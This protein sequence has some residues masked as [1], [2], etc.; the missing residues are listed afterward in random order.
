MWWQWIVCLFSASIS[1]FISS[2]ALLEYF[3]ESKYVCTG[4]DDDKVSLL[5]ALDMCRAVLGLLT[6]GLTV[7]AYRNTCKTKTDESKTGETNTGEANANEYKKYFRI[8]VGFLL[9]AILA[10]AVF[11]FVE[12]SDACVRCI[13]SE[14]T[15]SDDIRKMLGYSVDCVHSITFDQMRTNTNYCR[16]NIAN[17]CH[18]GELGQIYSERCLVWA[19]SDLVPEYPMMLRLGVVGLILQVV[20]CVMFVL[21]DKLLDDHPLAVREEGQSIALNVVGAI[22]E[23]PTGPTRALA[24]PLRRRRFGSTYYRT[25]NIEF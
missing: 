18:S 5:R 8:N 9:V 2:I 7:Y 3:G 25:S 16:S 19:C 15:F 14:D 23:G 10:V 11:I 12:R 17:K 21:V 4:S 24:R 22:G 20:V 13:G 6:F 1:M